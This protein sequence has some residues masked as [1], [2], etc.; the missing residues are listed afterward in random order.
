MQQSM[1]NHSI[2][3]VPPPVYFLLAI[4]LM[5]LLDR[6]VP[7][8]RWLEYPYRYTGILLIVAGFL[9]SAAGSML[10]RKLGTRLRPGA[11]ATTLVTGGPFRFT[12]NPMYLGLVTMLTGTG[13]VLGTLTPLVMIPLVILLLHFQFILREEQWMETWFGAAYLNYKEKVRRWL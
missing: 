9:L 3:R 4:I 1:M 2:P 10:F 12:R 8:M 6:Y 11:K 5:V 13:I 7:V